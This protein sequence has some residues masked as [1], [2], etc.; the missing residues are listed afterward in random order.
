[1]STPSDLVAV[2]EGVPPW[3]IAIIVISIVVLVTFVVIVLVAMNN[4]TRKARAKN[5]A[6][7]ANIQQMQQPLP[8][9]YR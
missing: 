1:M 6:I 8:G 4:K 9:I 2:D 5:L 3:V 7:Q